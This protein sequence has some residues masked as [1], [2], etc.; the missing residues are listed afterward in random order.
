MQFTQI[1]NDWFTH[2]YPCLFRIRELK[3]IFQE[4]DRDGNGYISM[5]EAKA[6]MKNLPLTD[7]EIETLVRAYDANDDG[8]LQYDEFVKFWNAA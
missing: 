2:T 7:D 1:T 4:F 5:D 3:N 8:R 6:A